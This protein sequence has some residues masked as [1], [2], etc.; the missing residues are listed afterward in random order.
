MLE[1]RKTDPSYKV[2]PENTH[3]SH[4]SWAGFLAAESL[5]SGLKTSG[6]LQAFPLPSAMPRHSRLGR[7]RR[8]GCWKH[9]MAQAQLCQ[10]MLQ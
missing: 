7:V 8:V 3:C 5:I 2:N 10:E 1:E 4:H 9:Q 6:L